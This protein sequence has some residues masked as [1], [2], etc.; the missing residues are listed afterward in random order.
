VL[1][2]SRRLANK[3]LGKA[4]AFF[5]TII[6]MATPGIG[7]SQIQYLSIFVKK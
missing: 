5:T 1:A 6:E 2:L 4:K 7:L 3:E